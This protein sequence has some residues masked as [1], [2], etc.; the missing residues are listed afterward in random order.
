MSLIKSLATVSG[1]TLASRV[2]GFARQ[3]MMAG[4]VGAGGSPVADAF[5]AAF[6][7]PNMFRRLLAEG[8][9]QAAFIPLFQGREAEGGA[10]EARRFA[11]EILS[12]LLFVLTL[13]TAAVMIATPLFVLLLASGF[14]Q[15]PERFHLS[16]I[17]TRI[18][19]P[20][21]ACMSVVG[22]LGGILNSLHRF[23]ATAGA[24][25][26]LN[27]IMLGAL[28][29]FA[30]AEQQVAGYAAAWSV[31]AAGVAQVALLMWGARRSGFMPRLVIPRYTKAVGRLIALG[32]PGFIAAGAL[33]INLIVGTNIASQQP[34]AVSWLLNADQL[35]QLPLSVIGIALGVVLLPAL[36][37]RVKAGDEAGAARTLNRA[38][39]VSTLLALP[40][41]LALV[42]LA[43]FLCAA[44]FQDLAADALSIFGG[45]HSAFTDE[46]VIMTGTALM[47]FG[48][49]VPAFVY[50]KVFS[51]AFFARE[52]TK[53]PMAYG[54]VA[55]GIN[56]ALSL[57]LFPVMGFLAVALA[58]TVATWVQIALQAERLWRRGILKPDARLI[59]RMPRIVL[60]AA[61]MAA[62]IWFAL[63]YTEAVADVLF[64]T[65]WLALIVYV[66]AGVALYATLCLV[67]GAAK[68]SDF[69]RGGPA[70]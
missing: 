31:F 27:V 33:Q 22:L 9:F 20:Y 5:W 6:R 1:M 70:I 39:E 30:N 37:R 38:I 49:G 14:G 29:P 48:A 46:D 69:R 65:Q 57:S 35:Y 47:L 41:G 53:T 3:V 59:G 50:N 7:L 13:L 10:E 23:A 56:V 2:L 19:F 28:I 44:L 54:L 4:I 21:L 62:A 17:Y 18:M 24:P 32:T 55:I 64:G 61:G 16:V 34:G 40:A 11:S 58:T 8:A 67:L 15:D 26:I 12:G 42:V 68:L 60:A 63:P 66:G 43:K 52:D 51:P 25:V 36:S 45:G